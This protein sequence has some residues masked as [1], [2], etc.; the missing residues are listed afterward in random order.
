MK[1]TI[2]SASIIALCLF[3]AILAVPAYA[4]TN[5]L[6]TS[7]VSHSIEKFDS[8]G[9]WTRTFAST[10]P[11]AP[12]GVV[13]SPVSNDVFVSTDTPTILRYRETGARLGPGGSRWS[14]SSVA[15]I[16]TNAVQ[17]LMF[18]SSGDLYVATNYGTSGYVVE[19]FKYPASQL[20]RESPVPSG[21]PIMTTVGRGDQM[22]FDAYGNICIASFGSPNTVQC[23]DPGTGTLKFDYASEIQPLAIQPVGIAFGPNNRLIVSSVFTG[24]VYEEAAERVGPMTLLASGMVAEVDFFATGSDGMLY[25]PSFHNAEAGCGNHGFSPDIVYKIDPSSGAVTN[26]ITDN[27]RGP[28]HMIFVPF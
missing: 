14:T 16:G 20:T 11:W 17:S 19:I 5:E 27:V 24:E 28:Y 10:G 18:D 26:F 2:T 23:Y 7:S 13:A 4:V 6:V 12:I 1:S 9:N 8:S 22:V 15:S 25:L 3:V 21:S